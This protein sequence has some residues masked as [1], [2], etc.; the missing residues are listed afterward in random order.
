MNASIRTRFAPAPTGYMHIGNIRSALMPALFA[1]KKGG[2]FI[3]RIED[4]DADR[5]M[6][7]GAEH[8]LSDLHWLG[9]SYDEGPLIAGPYAPYFQSQRSGIYADYLET[10]KSHN[11]IYRCF[12][13]V[14]EL[15][16]KR[17]RQR[18]TKQPPRY[19][20]TCLNYSP[21]KVAELLQVQ[22][23]FI[24]RLKLDASQVVIHDLARG[25]VTYDLHHFGDFPLT[26]QDGSYTFIF[27]NFVDDVTMK[28]THVFRGEEH[29][30]NTAVQGA[31]YK[32]YN[33]P[34][35]IYWHMPIICDASGKKLSKRDFGFALKDLRS[36]GYL[37]EA[38]LNYLATIGASF[39]QEIMS[40]T[41]MVELV[42]VEKIASAGHIHYDLEKLR[43]MNYEWIKR[44]GAETIAERCRPFLTQAYPEV[45]KLNAAE[46]LALIQPIHNDLHTLADSVSYL[47]FYFATPQPVLDEEQID[48]R[49][50]C[51]PALQQLVQALKTTTEPHAIAGF[52]KNLASQHTVPLKS[53]YHQ[54]RLALQGSPQGLTIAVLFTLLPLEVAKQRL[55]QW[56]NAAR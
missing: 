47:A 36:A 5:N 9:I 21:A 56:I 23:P 16:R 10:L 18:A 8:I 22:T 45:E 12:C 27:A 40:F 44:L 20:R 37:P 1:R 19:D 42:D 55:E 51:L 11:Q 3:I 7:V 26:R 34:T 30:S 14:E 6:D 41:Q 2:S 49:R 15:E 4:T 29:F 28:I 35:P 33:L 50:A 48:E 38:I 24:W 52:M 39:K 43:W 32:A 46:L 25:E 13:T 31:L 17:E 53:L 54:V